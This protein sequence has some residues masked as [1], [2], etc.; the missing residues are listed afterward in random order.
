MKKITRLALLS[1]I[2]LL[3]LF[4]YINYFT[5]VPPKDINE[6]HGVSVNRLLK[7]PEDYESFK[8]I[9]CEK[10]DEINYTV[11]Y[12]LII[13]DIGTLT[14]NCSK[15]DISG[16]KKGSFVYFKGVS[17]LETK[18]YILVSDFHIQESYSLQLSLIGLVIVILILF[19]VLK[20]DWKSFSFEIRKFKGDKNS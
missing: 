8:I 18:G 20:F 7:R 4:G 12:I 14:L 9:I 1:S 17:L 2:F 3:F 13:T 15:I 10:V 6:Y 5:Y 11:K 19:F 16:L